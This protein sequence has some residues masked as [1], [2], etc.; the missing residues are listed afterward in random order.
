MRTWNHCNDC[1]WTAH[2]KE[3]NF[4]RRRNTQKVCPL[5]YKKT[6]K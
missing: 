2:C 4:D 6:K 5:I 3:A 1:E